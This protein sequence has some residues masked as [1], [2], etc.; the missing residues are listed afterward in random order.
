MAT[1]SSKEYSFAAIAPEDCAKRTTGEI[2]S[3]VVRL[4]PTM[5]GWSHWLCFCPFLTDFS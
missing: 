1:L 4:K 2:H 3:C 5:S